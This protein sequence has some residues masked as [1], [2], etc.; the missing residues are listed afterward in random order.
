MTSVTDAAIELFS[1]LL[2]E[3]DV[4]NIS[5]IITQLVEFSRSPKLDKNPGRK[6]AILV[7]S[8]I[9]LLLAL[10]QVSNV[11]SRNVKD[12]FASGQISTIMAE[13]LK[14]ESL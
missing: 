2:A 1:L 12:A 7:N 8:T 13:F 11:G 4:H 14:V 3:Q 10:R 6:A 5:Q 9:A